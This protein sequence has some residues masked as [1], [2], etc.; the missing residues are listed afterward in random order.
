MTGKERSAGLPVQF[1]DH[2]NSNAPCWQAG[3]PNS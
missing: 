2:T 3:V 1:D